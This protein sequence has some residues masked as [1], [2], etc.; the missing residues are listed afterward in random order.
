MK[1]AR[2]RRALTAFYR[3]NNLVAWVELATLALAIAILIASYFIVTAESTADRLLSPAMVALLLISNLVPGVALLVLIGRRMAKRRAARSLVGGGGGLHVRLVAL[4]SLIAAVPTLLVVIFASLLFQYGVEFWFSDRARGMLENASILAQE[5]YAQNRD[6]VQAQT[7][8]MASD[9]IQ[10]LQE[11]PIENPLFQEAFARQVYQRELSEAAILVAKPGVGLQ[12]L[13]MVDPYVRGETNVVKPEVMEKIRRGA[14]AV[15]TE[16]NDRI[17]AVVPLG[18]KEEAYLWAARVANPKML[19]Q[20]QRADTVLQDY[21]RLLGRSRALQLQFNIALLAVSLLIVGAAVFIALAVADRIVRPLGDLVDAAQRIAGG[22]L[23]A[24]VEQP[25]RQDEI[26]SL[27]NAFNR[28]TRRIEEQTGALESRRAFIEAVLSGVSA[29]VVSVDVNGKILLMNS[30][31]AA[32]LKVGPL[33]AVGRS[34]G[35]L[36]PEL[37]A[38][39]ASGDRSEIVQFNSTGEAR[40]LAVRV[41]G[42]ESGR[43]LTFDDIT[44]QL[45]DQRRAAWSD[46]A[47]RIAHEIKNP[48][49]PIQL[50][51]ERL[52][53]RYGKQISDETGTFTR[54]TET[55]VRQVADL[56]R[57]VDEFSSFARMPKPVF[58]PESLTD[59]ARQSLF[60]HEVAHP[61]IRFNFEQ[62]EDVQPMVCDRRQIGQALTNLVK[63]A[64]EAIEP[65]SEVSEGDYTGEVTLSITRRNDPARLTVTVTDN[66][67]GLPQERDRLVEPYV[68][69]RVRGTGLGL[70]IVKKIVEEHFGTM[71]FADNPGGGTI[72][73]TSFDLDMLAN[74]ACDDA[75]I[76][77]DQDEKTPRL[78]RK[79]EG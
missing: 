54:L 35:D 39:A 13:I 8:T 26:G 33:H 16:T 29:G 14:P 63:N 7:V 9:L 55:I 50:A 68:T 58:R 11:A 49:T 76:D 60:L 37:G 47:R 59:I 71:Q 28:M 31:A 36:A 42:D 73:T 40:T 15:V 78:T 18:V 65:K 32:L 72:I 19:A 48:L 21:K 25:V 5:T 20:A 52:Q 12:T 79:G 3:R 56:R 41:V 44:Q 66:G 34:L 57:M 43:V 69:T 75:A 62:E 4:F 53:R 10:F 24:R 67:I 61:E 70:A 46:V 17:E 27:A 45:L 6:D 23:T 38:L 30:Q 64:V 74:I 77:L 2:W 51:A 1:P 22:D